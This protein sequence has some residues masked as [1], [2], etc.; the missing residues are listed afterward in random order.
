MRPVEFG[1]F[2]AGNSLVE[3]DISLHY[4]DHISLICDVYY[5]VLQIEFLCHSKSTVNPKPTIPDLYTLLI[6]LSVQRKRE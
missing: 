2:D 4:L 6:C 5:S 1:G 3:R